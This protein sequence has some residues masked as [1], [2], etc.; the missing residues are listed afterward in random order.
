M[1]AA[2]EVPLPAA[3][4]KADFVKLLRS[5]SAAHGLHVDV[6]SPAD[7]R[8]MSA[9]SPIT[10]NASVWRGDDEESV[11]SAMDF[12]D[13]LGR[14]WLTFHQ[15]DSRKRFAGFR[16]DLMPKIRRRWPGTAALPITADGGLPLARDLL[17][18]P[19]G[20]VVHPAAQAKY[21]HADGARSR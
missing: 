2:F 8:R 18:T 7:L 6:A 17:R 21:R 16:N 20:Y 5:V 12:A 3:A 14:V 15:G 10:L 9:V 4:D 11:L 1:V 19:T 13:H